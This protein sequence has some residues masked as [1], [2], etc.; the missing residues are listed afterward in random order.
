MIY[1]DF[2]ASPMLTYELSIIMQN[3][4]KLVDKECID[5]AFSELA[6]LFIGIATQ[7]IPL[8]S[9]PRPSK[10]PLSLY[11]LIRPLYEISKRKTEKCADLEFDLDIETTK[12]YFSI[13]LNI[14]FF[15][16]FDTCSHETQPTITKEEIASNLEKLAFHT[17]PLT[18]Q[19]GS[20]ICGYLKYEPNIYNIQDTAETTLNSVI[21]S[22]TEY[23]LARSSSKEQY[24]YAYTIYSISRLQIKRI[25]KKLTKKLQRSA[26]MMPTS[27]VIKKSMLLPTFFAYLFDSGIQYVPSLIELFNA[28]TLN[29]FYEYFNALNASQP[30]YLREHLLTEDTIFLL[31]SSCNLYVNIGKLSTIFLREYCDRFP[32][33][34]TFPGVLFTFFDIVGSLYNELYFPYDSFSHILR[35]PHSNQTLALPVKKTRK[36]DA[37]RFLIQL[38]EELYIKAALINEV[39]LIAVYQEYIHQTISA[40]SLDSFAHFGISFFQNLYA[41][42]KSYDPAMT[43]DHSFDYLENLEAFNKFARQLIDKR[44]FLM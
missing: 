16:Q 33:I 44:L 35:L 2:T 43:K 10:L 31:K 22:N 27:K 39:E 21:K 38:C 4:G 42:Y 30:C 11:F 25:Q 37:F 29:I 40:K 14:I 36:Q 1:A 26:K 9:K 34:L 41:N 19:C 32:F 20:G 7:M 28:V 5:I 3:I 6:K 13:W 18:F 15:K 8:M 23:K 12:L 24:I 17:P